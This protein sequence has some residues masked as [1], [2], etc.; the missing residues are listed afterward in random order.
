MITLRAP[1]P[2]DVDRLLIWEND[3]GLFESLPQAAPLSRFQIWQYIENYQADPFATH[4]LRLMIVDPATDTTVGHIDLY[5]FSPADRRAGIA[6]YIDSPHR[7][8]GYATMALKALEDYATTRLGMH[9][10]WAHI[11]IDN[12][13]SIALF[14][15]AGYKSAGRLRSWLRRSDRYA[16]ALIFQKLFP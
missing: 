6:I 12:T 13:P 16:D 14:T 15:T 9:Q 3:P 2:S 10:L 11:A 4:E 1:E 5:D 7:H 8:R